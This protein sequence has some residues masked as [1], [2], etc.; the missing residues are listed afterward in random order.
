M[1]TSLRSL[2]GRLIVFV[3]TASMAAHGSAPQWPTRLR[4]DEF[5]T[6]S[7][8]LDLMMHIVSRVQTGD[9]Y[10]ASQV[11]RVGLARP[12]PMA[13]GLPVPVFPLREFAQRD[14]PLCTG[15]ESPRQ[16]LT[17]DCQLVQVLNHDENTCPPDL[18]CRLFF[19]LAEF[20][21][22]DADLVA[23]IARGFA[24]VKETM[25]SPESVAA[26]WGNPRLQAPGMSNNAVG[27]WKS[28]YCDTPRP[29]SG[30]LVRLRDNI[31]TLEFDR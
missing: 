22:R 27:G 18:R 12:P 3:A 26:R 24:N 14:R 6:A 4:I 19:R 7:A 9:D 2:V 13:Q 21:Y 8:F 20:I 31:F 29:A 10:Y 30:R 25:P 16:W 23:A 5:Q 11:R 28:L 17:M 15:T 1:H